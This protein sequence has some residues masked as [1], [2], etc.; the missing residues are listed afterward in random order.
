MKKMRS[1]ILLL[2]LI[3]ICFS[4]NA[5]SQDYMQWGLPEGAK[6]R[7]GK[8]EIYG[9]IT[10]SPDSSLLAVPTRI[11]IWLYDGFTG[12]AL[13][14]LS[15]NLDYDG[16]T[17]EALYFLSS[18]FDYY[19]KI[20]FSPDGKTLACN[21]TSELFL[22][23]VDTGNL[24]LTISEHTS[25]ISSI[26][27]NPN[28]KTI[29][30]S[31]R[32]YRDGTV[33]FW[34]VSTG[35]LKNTLTVH[36]GDIDTIVFNPDGTVL[37]SCGY[38]GEDTTMKLWD[39]ATGELKA[40]FILAEDRS[41][42]DANIAFSPD[43]STI[44]SCGGR[45]A[46]HVNLWDITSGTL[47]NTLI[48]HIGGVNDVAFSPDSS[49][50]ASGS[51]DNTVCLWDVS[52]GNYKTTLITHT[53]D[54]ASVAYSPDGTTFASHSKDGTILLW[55][56]EKL[57]R[58]TTITGHIS[59][60][61]QV[62]F[63]PDGTTIVS[64]SRDTKVRLWDTTTGKNKKTF[65][66]HLGPVISVAFSPDGRTIASSGGVIY[67]D[68]WFADDYP[69]R[70]WDVPSGSQ[71]AIIVGHERDIHRVTFSPDGRVLTTYASNLKPIF[72]DAATGDFLW[73][74][75][76]IEKGVGDITFSP[77]SLKFVYGDSTGIHLWDFA[78]RKHITTFTGSIPK[79]STIVFSPDGNTIAAGGSGQEVHL[80]N[81]Y[82]GERNTIITGHVGK[83]KHVLFSPD[84]QTLVT[85]SFW[86][87]GTLRFWDPE[88]GALKL[89]LKNIPDGEY[90]LAISPDGQTLALSVDAGIILLWDYAS[91][92]NPSTSTHEADV[93]KDGVVDV[94]DLVVVAA[95]FGKTGPNDADVNED[96]VVNIADLIKVAAALDNAAAAPSVINRNQKFA[97]TRADVQKWLTQAQQL[98]LTDITSQK[99]IRFLEQL[100]LI[101][102][103]K[104]TALLP[105]YPNPFNPET[106][107]PYQLAA[108]AD[109]TIQIYSSAGQ[110]IR[111]LD[112][113]HQ[114]AGLYQQR[115]LAAHWDGKNELGELVAS[116]VYFYTLT[117]GEFSLTRRMVIQK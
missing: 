111:T 38:E 110:L 114:S 14:L 96:G 107:I 39:V 76:G 28:G 24:K 85:T 12:E 9:N 3:S 53:D 74:F 59:G 60:F 57:E 34:D 54:V 51:M 2:V 20:A 48:G 4:P 11:G 72:W 56:A 52:T 45:W 109:V 77:D 6:M 75:T 113:G 116:G 29:A 43:G 31:S 100:L 15:R 108:P 105:N 83:F 33:K 66:G 8:G 92:I 25:S 104:K 101:L 88:N 19:S 17:G 70:L 35:E 5:S 10:F 71:K 115:N 69:I 27:F 13:N 23:D 62:A 98:N 21:N 58:R 40:T 94:S 42:Y 30:T 79:T 90:N 50:L 37:V 91:L 36:E 89:M 112:M 64:G 47:K 49:T 103:P 87:D 86:G 67:E 73:T 82:T 32:Y 117:A 1:T 16:F 65:M 63:S 84:G 106:W 93:N 22:W 44:A 26:V 95:N 68:R 55:D 81:V 41:V 80:W 99:G 97:P 61:S 46:A 7:I 18:N 102:T 78:S